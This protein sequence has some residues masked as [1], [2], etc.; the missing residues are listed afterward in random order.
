MAS[1]LGSGMSGM[2]VG[3][4]NWSQWHK[5]FRARMFIV[6]K[7]CRDSTRNIL[8]TEWLCARPPVCKL[9]IPNYASKDSFNDLRDLK[10]KCHSPTHMLEKHQ[11]GQGEPEHDGPIGAIVAL[12][13]SS[14]A[15]CFRGTSIALIRQCVYLFPTGAVS[16]RGVTNLKSNQRSRPFTWW[17]LIKITE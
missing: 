13:P 14:L 10:G 17:Q 9:K 16:H 15:V 12:V 2:A 5:R 7:G 4:P 8:V 11:T 6:W 3:F 1:A